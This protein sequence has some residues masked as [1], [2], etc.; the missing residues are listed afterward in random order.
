MKAT[1]KDK[2]KT[3]RE[4]PGQIVAAQIAQAEDNVRA[5]CG[6]VESIKRTIRR[7][8]RGNLPKEPT[9]LK[10][11]V[12]EGEWTDTTSSK[13]FL[14]P[15]SGPDSRSRML[16][17]TSEEGLTHLASQDIWYMDGNF[18]LAPKVFQQMYIIRAK[19]GN[20]AVTCAYALLTGK[21]QGQYEEMLKAVTRRCEDLGFSPDPT[22]VHMDFEQAAIN[23]V[24]NTFGPHVQKF[25]LFLPPHAEY[26]A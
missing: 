9:T 16:V 11:L 21:S 4:L 22:T 1:M 23:A 26:M 7:V 18:S 14:I 13:R 19:L 5:E 3:S 6:K 15:D 25:R 20:S 17:F 24:R 10:E 2:G 12:L 8:Q